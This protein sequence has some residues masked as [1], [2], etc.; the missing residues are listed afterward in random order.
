MKHIK[1]SLVLYI[2]EYK[3]PKII[4]LQEHIT[5]LFTEQITNLWFLESFADVS[6]ISLLF[7]VD[8][9]R[10]LFQFISLVSLQLE[11]YV[12]LFMPIA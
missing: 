4:K 10:L 12:S 9:H 6:R 7:R 1:L 3:L 8:N 2:K 11:N 5:C